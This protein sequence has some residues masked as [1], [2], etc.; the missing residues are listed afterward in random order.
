L[1]SNLSCLGAPKI[2]NTLVTKTRVFFFYINASTHFWTL[3][4]LSKC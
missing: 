3:K 2:Q 4:I 1:G